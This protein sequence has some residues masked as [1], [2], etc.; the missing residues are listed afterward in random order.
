MLAE[1]KL[2][3]ISLEV[4]TDLPEDVKVSQYITGFTLGTG[5]NFA[6]EKVGVACHS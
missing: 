4:T 1:N 2:L 5:S 6:I 3:K